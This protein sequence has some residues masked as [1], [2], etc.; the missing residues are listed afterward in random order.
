M[1]EMMI[2]ALLECLLHLSMCTL[3][4]PFKWKKNFHPG[5][6]KKLTNFKQKAIQ[7]PVSQIHQPSG[8]TGQQAGRNSVDAQNPPWKCSKPGGFLAS[9]GYPSWVGP[10]FGLAQHGAFAAPAALEQHHWPGTQGDLALQSASAEPHSQLTQQWRA[11]VSGQAGSAASIQCHTEMNV[12][13][14]VKTWALGSQRHILPSRYL[15]MP[16]S[17]SLSD[18]IERANLSK[19]INNIF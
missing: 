10:M 8:Y 11:G 16:C 12:L 7:V 9:P 4:F 18:T 3:F 5:I 2:Y 14:M 13:N 1:R 17:H 19:E 15:L 6:L